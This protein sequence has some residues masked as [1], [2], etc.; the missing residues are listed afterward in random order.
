M[1]DSTSEAVAEKHWQ[2][3]LQIERT[4]DGTPVDGKLDICLVFDTSW[5][6]AEG[7]APFLQQN[8]QWHCGAHAATGAQCADCKRK[9]TPKTEQSN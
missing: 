5:V 2:K 1:D 3:A 8:L 7:I 6:G 9:V 4:R